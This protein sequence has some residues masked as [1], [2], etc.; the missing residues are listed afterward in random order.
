[1]KV[2]QHCDKE[3]NPMRVSDKWPDAFGGGE[4]RCFSRG[5]KR[6]PEGSRKPPHLG[7]SSE[8]NPRG[9]QIELCRTGEEEGGKVIRE[10]NGRIKGL[11]VINWS[12]LASARSL[13][14][15]A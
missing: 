9:R 8:Q 6:P 11:G 2:V 13:P 1:V 12:T 10:P 4:R 3:R 5:L 7:R 14:V 15:R